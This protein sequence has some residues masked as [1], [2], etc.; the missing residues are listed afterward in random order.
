MAKSLLYIRVMQYLSVIITILIV[1]TG[2]ANAVNLYHKAEVQAKTGDI[3]GMSATYLQILNKNPEATKARLGYA[4]ASSWLGH[5]A[6][7]QQQFKS[8]LKTQP[9]NLQA[10]EGLGY[11]Y[12]WAKQYDDA[13]IQFSK[14]LEITPDHIAARKGL[15]L[16]YLW[17]QQAQ[18][19][20]DLLKVLAQQYPDDAEVQAALG[21]A[22]LALHKDEAA[23]RAFQRALIIAPGRP[24]AISGLAT[25][26]QKSNT[27][28]FI[29]WAG[30][31]SNGGSTGLRELILGYWIKD[32]LRFWARYDNSL[33]L[34]NP[35]LA[36]S[37]Q[38]ATTFYL[39]ALNR[40]NEEWQASVEVGK[41]NLPDDADQK[42]F[43]VEAV[44]IQQQDVFKL[45]AQLSPHS[46]GYTDKLIYSA[47]GF[48]VNKK[49]RLEPSFY[50]S[51]SG[52]LDDKEW[53]AVMFG[54][55]VDEERWSIGLSA[56]F[57][58]ISSSLDAADGAVFTS[59]V[60]FSY[61]LSQKNRLNLAIRYEET[62]TIHF[63]TT[64]VGI[65]VQLP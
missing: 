11:D 60:V 10:L 24:D 28:D 23:M 50:L 18:Q 57:G 5:H 7:A 51:S 53:R 17:S 43:K 42:I 34:D 52:A 13:L 6:L 65:A 32:D 29:A 41:R 15:A 2:A 49:W 21:Q 45:G 61:P 20:L 40:F 55:Y 26:N 39:G 4:T 22:Q 63:T 47:F 59:N 1:T 62:P 44:N 33:S 36:R 3:S 37:G 14:V 25:I 54:E 58:R 27:F 12:A 19:A 9:D 8:V 46:K 31:T 56:G 38:D 30:D 64:L 16:T 48:P 35:A